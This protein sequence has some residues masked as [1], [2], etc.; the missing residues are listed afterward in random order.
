MTVYEPEEAGE[1]EGSP[2]TMTGG[3]PTG[4]LH[5]TRCALCITLNILEYLKATGLM[6]RRKAAMLYSTFKKK[7]TFED[8]SACVRCSATTRSVLDLTLFDLR[9]QPGFSGAAKARFTSGRETDGTPH[10]IR[11][12]DPVLFEPEPEAARPDD[13]P[14]VDAKGGSM[15]RSDGERMDRADVS[16]VNSREL[17]PSSAFSRR[18][19]K[20]A[21]Q[22]GVVRPNPV[23]SSV[24]RNQ[25]VK[26]Q[27]ERGEQSVRLLSNPTRA[28]GATE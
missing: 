15:V 26:V 27:G 22:N 16:K 6:P 18:L 19:Y 14:A 28:G 5:S 12:K 2:S 8:H 25:D 13:G 23:R 20:T 1:R 7:L 11:P 3:R 10:W 4:G 9:M 17:E 21:D 24:L